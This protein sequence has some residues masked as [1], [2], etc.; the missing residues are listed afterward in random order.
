MAL[1]GLSVIPRFS[2]N[3]EIVFGLMCPGIQ[4]NPLQIQSTVR[5]WR[6]RAMYPGDHFAVGDKRKI[7]DTL[8]YD[9]PV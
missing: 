6:Q 4:A 9:I 7:R 1:G 3:L 5:L 8:T 2:S